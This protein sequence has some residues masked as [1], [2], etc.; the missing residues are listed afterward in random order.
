MSSFLFGLIAA[1]ALAVCSAQ[2]LAMAD[3]TTVESADVG[4]W[5]R[6]CD[7]DPTL[8]DCAPNPARPSS[9]RASDR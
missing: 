2:L 6:L 4:E 3:V 5:V 7:S 8:D 9:D 1:A